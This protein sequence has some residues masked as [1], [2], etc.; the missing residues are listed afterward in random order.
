MI[1]S[2]EQIR[3]FGGASFSGVDGG[4]VWGDFVRN[5]FFFYNCAILDFCLSIDYQFNYISCLYFGEFAH[6]YFEN[7]DYYLNLYEYSLQ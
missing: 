2:L 7:I 4:S 6:W 3:I 1:F 5:L